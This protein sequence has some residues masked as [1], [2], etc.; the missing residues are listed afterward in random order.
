MTMSRAVRRGFAAVGVVLA[1]A[2][3]A[4]GCASNDDAAGKAVLNVYAAAS[5]TEAFTEIADEYEKV[6]DVDV[7]L[8]FAGSSALVNQIQQG[9]DADVIA[10]A[11]QATMA[12]LGEQA[13]DP[14]VFA[15]NTLVIVT[16]PGNPK[17]IVNFAGLRNPDIKTVVC[18]VEVPCGAATAQVEKNTGVDLDPVSE[19]TSVSAVLAKVTSG[20]AD[21]GLVYVTDAR[22]AGDAVA[23]VGDAAFARVVNS[24]PIATLKGTTH[25][26]DA[27]MFV[28]MVLGETGA[29]YLGAAGFAPPAG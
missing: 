16:A 9:A 1:V 18:A 29:E 13:V 12:R 21:A 10:T 24:Y 19:E 15:T 5:L 27:Q 8:N 17:N 25:S 23:T 4:T 14:K 2:S 22:G 3:A 11:N 28:G 7:K 20:Q 6:H 26:E